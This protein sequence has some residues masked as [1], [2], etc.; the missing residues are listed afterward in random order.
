MAKPYISVQ[1]VAKENTVFG[2]KVFEACLKSLLSADYASQIVVVDN[3]CSTLVREM[4]SY[5]LHKF[6]GSWV[7]SDSDGTDFS[8]VRNT[9]I[10]LTDPETDY[11]HWIDTDEVY[12]PDKLNE[13][14]VH[15]GEQEESVVVL[16]L[17]HF[18]VHP[19]VLQAVYPKDVIHRYNHKLAWGRGVHESLQHRSPGGTRHYSMPYL[20]YGYCRRQWRTA[21]KWLHYDY[22]EH[23]HVNHY[24]MEN[25]NGEM[26]PYFRHNRTPDQVVADRVLVSTP[27]TDIYPQSVV[28]LGLC[29]WVD[30]ASWV[31]YLQSLD[32]DEFW[33][34]WQE[35]SNKLGN[36][37]DTLDPIVD[38]AVKGNWSMI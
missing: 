5:L 37:E 20:H 30:E 35:M 16:N 2:G 24:K 23:G 14:A 26:I 38:M 34:E 15:L 13:L 9:A 31:S 8:S 22:I 28:D 10:N 18:M 3:G 19:N 6:C 33:D 11:I 17:V 7:L 12:Y 4:C 21:L 29:G 25:V 32:S 36:W 1:I 27:F